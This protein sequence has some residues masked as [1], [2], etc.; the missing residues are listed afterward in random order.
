MMAAM[1]WIDSGPLTATMKLRDVPQAEWHHLM[2]KRQT[3]VKV[4]LTRDCRCLVQFVGDAERMAGPLGFKDADDFIERGLKLDPAEIRLAVDWLKI[5]RPDEAIPKDVVVK[6]AKHGGDRRSEQARENQGSNPT[7][8]KR[9]RDY[10]LARLQR[11]RP[12][13]F[14]CVLAGE[15]SANAAAIEAGFRKQ[16]TPV[17]RIL[18][19]VAKLSAEERAE[20]LRALAELSTEGTSAVT[21]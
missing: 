16:L 21:S 7:L 9:G 4:H 10:D 15:L 14:Q 12:E 13:L 20:L 18:R 8:K 6:L 19:L 11:D 17:E 5:N 1:T 3:F 2:L